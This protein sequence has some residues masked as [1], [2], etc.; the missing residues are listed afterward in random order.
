MPIP[1]SHRLRDEAC[2][3]ATL[4]WRKSVSAAV[5]I[6]DPWYAAQAYAWCGRFA[7]PSDSPQLLNLSFRKADDGKDIYQR[8]AATA[9]PLRALVELGYHEK[10]KMKFASVAETSLQTMTC[11]SR[12]EAC[13]LVFQAI[14]IAPQPLAQIAF[15]WLRTGLNPPTHWRQR[16]ALEEGLLQAVSLGLIQVGQLDSFADHALVERVTKR[17]ERGETAYPRTFFWS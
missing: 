15:E 9:W 1:S 3:H 6:I 14:A 8:V 4:D 5:Q 11:S 7:P 13:F 10:A 2:K 12:A 16:R 17:T